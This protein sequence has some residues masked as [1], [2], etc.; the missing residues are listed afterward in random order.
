MEKLSILLLS[1]FC[2]LITLQQ[3]WCDAGCRLFPRHMALAWLKLDPTN[4]VS[5]HHMRTLPINDAQ[6]DG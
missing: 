6:E 2:T 4:Y 1:F 5:S 3:K